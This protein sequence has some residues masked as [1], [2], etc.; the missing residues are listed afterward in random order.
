MS[1]VSHTLCFMGPDL[2]LFCEHPFMSLEWAIPCNML[3]FLATEFS[4]CLLSQPSCTVQVYLPVSLQMFRAEHVASLEL[5]I[6]FKTWQ[7]WVSCV[8]EVAMRN[9]CSPFVPYLEYCISAWSEHQGIW[10]SDKRSVRAFHPTQLTPLLP[11]V[12][13]LRTHVNNWGKKVV[14]QA[15][16]S[17]LFS[18][19]SLI[20]VNLYLTVWRLIVP[21]LSFARL[22]RLCFYQVSPRGVLN[23]V[24]QSYYNFL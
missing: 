4:F 21:S 12:C 8:E 1:S 19:I 9:K 11:G 6:A 3:Q 20:R 23:E 14:C 2:P 17:V 22:I 15:G 24:E 13:F 16:I 18:F 7:S 10:G 5:M